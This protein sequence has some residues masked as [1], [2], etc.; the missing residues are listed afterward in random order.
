MS[1]SL[2]Y[3]NSE[4]STDDTATSLVEYVVLLTMLVSGVFLGGEIF[5]QTTN[6]IT[7]T[8]VSSTSVA[9]NASQLINLDGELGAERTVNQWLPLAQMSVATLFV[10]VATM[11]VARN[12][13]RRWGGN[14]ENEM[15]S[16]ISSPN[17][18]EKENVL[19]NKRQE[20]FRSLAGENFVDALQNFKVDR[21][22]TTHVTSVGPRTPASQ[23]RRLMTS[24]HIH[25][26]IVCALDNTVLG[27]ISD[28]DMLAKHGETAQDIMTSNPVCIT[29]DA[30]V[31]PTVTIMLERRI[32]CLP[33][34]HGEKLVGMITITD[35]ML[36][37]QCLL[38]VLHIKLTPSQA[39]EPAHA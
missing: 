34:L 22:M 39:A 19:Y 3:S 17:D 7:T 6:M 9:A 21:L 18:S 24:K 1:T 13:M 37:L 35:L 2:S 29:P 12:V 28:R 36:A 25:H 30:A 8:E 16:M 26:V 11:F 15:Q 14:K 27:V 38:Q 4:T 23:V 31:L 10:L 33:I 32:S 20:L 5:D